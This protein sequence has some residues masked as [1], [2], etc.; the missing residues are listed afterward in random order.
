VAPAGLAGATGLLPGAPI[1]VT[2]SGTG[3]HADGIRGVEWAPARADRFLLAAAFV[4]ADPVL[5]QV[6]VTVPA[7]AASLTA[8]RALARDTWV[9]VTSPHRPGATPA[10]TALRAFGTAAAAAPAPADGYQWHA[11]LVGV[12]E[13]HGTL[14]L[15][16]RLV[17]RQTM[18]L[19]RG[20][21]VMLE[22]SGFGAR[23]DGIRLVRPNRAA[24]RPFALRATF[25]AA[26]HATQYL[27]FTVPVPTGTPQAATALL[28]GDWVTVTSPQGATEARAAVVLLDAYDTAQR[29]RRYTWPAELVA[30]DAATGTVAVSAPVEPH[31]LRY[32]DRF[33]AGEEVVLIWAPASEDTVTAVRYLEPRAGSVLDH[34]YVLPVT[35]TAAEAGRQRIR[36]RTAV[37]AHTHGLWAA[38]PAGTPIAVTTLFDQGGE[39]AAILAV[40]APHPL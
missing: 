38:L 22:W 36:F 4:G 3:H 33:A 19:E 12:D 8:A 34:G 1:E 39:T 40:D 11:A 23:A 31:V 26:D 2:W 30:F 16:A 35:F 9:T 7:T 29:A 27:T 6:T 37:P 10:V 21:P 25:V 28:P 24:A 32:L 17:A 5:Q 20:A 13:R 15:R 14:T 18:A